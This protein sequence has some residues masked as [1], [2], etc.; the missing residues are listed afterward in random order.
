MTITVTTERYGAT[1]VDEDAWAFISTLVKNDKFYPLDFNCFTGDIITHGTQDE[2]E[3]IGVILD[4]TW[5]LN[6]E[7][8]GWWMCAMSHYLRGSGNFTAVKT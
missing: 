5:E 3:T 6:P 2:A 4:S 7:G 8:W 1:Q